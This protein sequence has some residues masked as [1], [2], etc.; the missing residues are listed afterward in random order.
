MRRS[1]RASL[2][3]LWGL[4]VLGELLGVGFASTPAYADGSAGQAVTSGD[5]CYNRACRVHSLIDSGALTLSGANTCITIGNE[6]ICEVGGNTLAFTSGAGGFTVT[7]SIVPTTAN[8]DNLG[9]ASNYFGTL[10]ANQFLGEGT[11][12]VSATNIT[13][14]NSV[15]GGTNVVIGASGCSGSE[16]MAL[17]NNGGTGSDP[18]VSACGANT[19]IPLDITSKG[20]SNIVL[21][22]GTSGSV[23]PGSTNTFSLGNASTTWTFLYLQDTTGALTSEPSGATFGYNSGTS[24]WTTAQNLTTTGASFI[25]AGSS[26]FTTTGPYATSS[27]SV[28]QF[29]C[30]GASG[31]AFA[32]TGA[33]QT[34]ILGYGVPAASTTAGSATTVEGQPGGAGSGATAGGAGGAVNVFGNNGGNGTAS[35]LAGAGGALSL[36]SGNAGTNGGGG[37]AQSGAIDIDVGNPTGAAAAGVIN[38]GNGTSGTSAN[39]IAIGTSTTT[40]PV[41]IAGGSGA[42]VLSTAFSSSTTKTVTVPSGSVCTCTD[43]TA[44]VAIKCS[45]SSTTLTATETSSSSDAFSVICL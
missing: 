20:S 28:P 22:P 30:S 39:S 41:K 34:S 12:G 31:C 27:T 16:A 2:R 5:R 42:F 45:V 37:G 11:S 4:V 18:Q 43:Q 32:A 23:V 35:G 44:V 15:V 13:A 29:K 8:A 33:G 19:N 36:T 25:S 6:S 21:T 14:G 9:S 7:A 40:K 3:H 24:T 10:Y 38:I 26:G 1:L 17:Q